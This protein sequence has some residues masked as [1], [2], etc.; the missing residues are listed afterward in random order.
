[1]DLD[2][3]T[4]AKIISGFGGTLNLVLGLM[5]VL[6]SICPLAVIFHFHAVG[7][8]SWESTRFY[9][10]LAYTWLLLLTVLMTAVPLSMGRRVLLTRDF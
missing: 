8:L 1:M 9:L 6:L 10:F 5:G 3:K 2:V 4:P 7:M